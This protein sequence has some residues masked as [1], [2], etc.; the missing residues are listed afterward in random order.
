VKITK[1][2]L[3]SNI[4]NTLLAAFTFTQRWLLNEYKNPAPARP[5]LDSRLK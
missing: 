1:K 5:I 4:K 3:K 2:Y